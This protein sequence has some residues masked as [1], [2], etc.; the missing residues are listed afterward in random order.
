L[1]RGDRSMTPRTICASAFGFHGSRFVTTQNFRGLGYARR[2]G[3]LLVPHDA[4][5]AAP[6]EENVLLER[7]ED[8]GL[9]RNDPGRQRLKARESPR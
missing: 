7:A 1:E 4:P 2:D 3:R 6:L 9:P 5:L 8:A